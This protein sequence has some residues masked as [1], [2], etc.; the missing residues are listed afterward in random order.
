M[1]ML[2]PEFAGIIGRTV[3]ESSPSWA[4]D[5]N[6]ENPG[7]PNIMV[8]VLDDTGWSDFG[9][10]GSEIQTPTFDSI[11]E[12]GARYTNF[13]V[14]PLCSPTRAS[15]LTGRNHHAVGMRFLADTDT[16]FPN[17]RGCVHPDIP[18]LPEVLRGEGY[19]TYLVGKWHLAPLHEIT[20]AGPYRNWPLS[21]GFDRF[22][23]FL[24]G[25]TDQFTPELFEDNHQVAVPAVED[26][27]LSED[28]ADRAISY[29]AEHTSYRPGAPF[30][31]QFAM[32]A[33]HAPFQ[34]PREYVEK[35]VDVFSKGWDQTRKDRLLRQVQLGV[36]T[37]GS[38][39]TDRD[40]DI[41]PWDTL[42]DDE[43]LLFTHL[44]AAYAGFLDHADAQV[45]RIVQALRDMDQ[46]DNTILIV[47]S[48]NGASR[49]GGQNGAV[50]CNAP[51]SGNPQTVAEQI[52]KLQDIGGPDGPAHYPMGWAMAGNTPFRKYKQ[53]VDLGGVRSPFVLSWPS[54]FPLHNEIRRNFIHVIDVMPTLLEMAGIPNPA[55]DGSSFVRSLNEPEAPPARDTQYWEMLGH[56][57]IWHKDWKAVTEHVPGTPFEQDKWRL[58]NTVTDPSES[59]DLAA[60]HPHKVDQLQQLWWSEAGD[61]QVLPLDDRPLVQLLDLRS[62]FALTA[63]KQVVLHSGSGHVPFS[64]G[65][66]GSERSMRITARLK[67]LQPGDAGVL[68][69]SGNSRG[70]YS[71]YL[72]DGSVHFEHTALGRE[73]HASTVD[74]L[75]NGDVSIGVE[76]QRSPDRS[77]HAVLL[78]NG[79]P[80]AKVHVPLTSAHLSFW[81]A[82]IG[83]DVGRQVSAN[84]EGEFPLRAGVIQNITVDFHDSPPIAEIAEA[85]E[86]I[87]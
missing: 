80:V 65:I 69:S 7:R 71:L 62:P 61:H 43:Q 55:V 70:G 42:N 26:Y 72:Q 30:Y 58:Y 15:L 60:S 14:T 16:G 22:Y 45:G 82:D 44:Q 17:S 77:S 21:R 85:L 53:Y 57:A 27:H 40:G 84:Y 24:D 37:H 36:M 13:H 5:K 18:M 75:P 63:R 32:G 54:G 79:Q 46:L 47:M 11:A 33:T 51:Y 6:A 49:E 59:T 68:F 12:R 48:D 20:P 35:Y 28:L 86:H 87:E 19:G 3:P 39:L 74:P 76:L 83:R 56:R 50:D 23:G 34:V 8:V 9:C 64:S 81:G 25:C 2:E 67:G 66:T 73:A 41:R 4:R 31:M 29:V 10:F 38:V 1:N 78:V 52:S